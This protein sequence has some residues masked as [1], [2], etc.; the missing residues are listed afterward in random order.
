MIS[1]SRQRSYALCAQTWSVG[2]NGKDC[3]VDE[4]LAKKCR[5][6]LQVLCANGRLLDVLL[7]A[8]FFDVVE[9]V[10]DSC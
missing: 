7:G 2:E 6:T 8:A 9:E 3:R 1:L 10:E 4:N 5:P